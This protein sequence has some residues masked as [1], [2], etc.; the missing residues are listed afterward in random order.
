M[1]CL[2]REGN[3]NSKFENEGVGLEKKTMTRWGQIRENEAKNTVE[4]KHEAYF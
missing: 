2:F 4:K 3:E 1:S